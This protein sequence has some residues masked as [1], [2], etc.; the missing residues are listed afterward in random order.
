LEQFSRE[1]R[2]TVMNRF[3]NDKMVLSTLEAY[4]AAERLRV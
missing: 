1:G 2:S 3:T 4:A